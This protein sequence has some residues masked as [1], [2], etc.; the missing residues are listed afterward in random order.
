MTAGTT[1]RS[2]QSVAVRGTP[3]VA[4]RD[5]VSARD[6]HERLAAMLRQAIGYRVVCPEGRVGVLAAVKPEYDDVIPDRIEIASGLFIVAVVS[7]GFTDVVSVDP[8]RG[9]V[10]IGSVP[11]RRRGSRREIARRVRRFV[12]ASGR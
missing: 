1:R 10:F 7:V 3:S 4:G 2:G 12:R 11:E 5:V 9:R 6:Q 8:L